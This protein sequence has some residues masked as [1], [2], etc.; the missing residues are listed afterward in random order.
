MGLPFSG[1]VPQLGSSS[2]Y[3]FVGV[4]EITSGGFSFAGS[5]FGGSGQSGTFICSGSLCKDNCISI[6]KCIEQNGKVEA[7]TCFLCGL[8]EI[9]KDRSCQSTKKCG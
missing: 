8:D 1:F 4:K 6:S 2:P 7:S 5:A 3:Q 9:Y